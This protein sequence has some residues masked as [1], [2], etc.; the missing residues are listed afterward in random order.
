VKER[1]EIVFTDEL[2]ELIV[3]AEVGGREGGECG[4]IELRLLTNRGD[5]LSRAIDQQRAARVAVEQEALERFGDRAEIVFGESPACCTNGHSSLPVQSCALSL[6]ASQFVS[7]AL[8]ARSTEFRLH[9]PQQPFA[10]T[11]QRRSSLP[12]HVFREQARRVDA[13]SPADVAERRQ[14]A[15]GAAT[16]QVTPAPPNLG[17][18]DQQ[19]DN[20]TAEKPGGHRFGV[21]P[22]CPA[23]H[24]VL[25]AARACAIVTPSAYSRSPPTGNP[26]A[27]LVTVTGREAS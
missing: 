27:I 22:F 13:W 9:S 6:A 16:E 3:G 14:T 20:K 7:G 23:P 21:I 18:P 8:D 24:M 17:T 26:R 25:L 10:T 2:R 4:G 12:A 11:T 19:A 1:V 5:E 15:D